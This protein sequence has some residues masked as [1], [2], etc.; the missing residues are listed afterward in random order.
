MRKLVST[1]YLMEP[2]DSEVELIAKKFARLRDWL[3]KD[4]SST[5]IGLFLNEKL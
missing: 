5:S 3:I 4:P 2:Y 1:L